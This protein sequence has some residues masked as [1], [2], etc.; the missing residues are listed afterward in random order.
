MKLDQ[1]VPQEEQEVQAFPVIIK[2]KEVPAVAM[3]NPSSQNDVHQNPPEQDPSP[4][5]S[6]SAKKSRAPA[7]PPPSVVPSEPPFTTYSTAMTGG[8]PIKR[9]SRVLNPGTTTGKISEKQPAMSFQPTGQPEK[10]PSDKQPVLAPPDQTSKN[11]IKEKPAS[12]Q[13]L[14]SQQAGL[15]QQ[16]ISRPLSPITGQTSELGSPSSNRCPHCK[17]HSWLPHSSG[18]PN[19]K[20]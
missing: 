18:C 19:R 12:F 14:F 5:R 2:E 17:L 7:P 9:L 20:S 15:E 13:A 3:K 6:S 10:K 4:S 11:L 8:L 16:P 1:I